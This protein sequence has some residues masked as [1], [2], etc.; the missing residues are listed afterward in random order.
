MCIVKLIIQNF[1]RGEGGGPESGSAYVH[2]M[3]GITFYKEYN[4]FLIRHSQ[5][6]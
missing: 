5:H 3:V 6:R 2:I 4:V 1:Q